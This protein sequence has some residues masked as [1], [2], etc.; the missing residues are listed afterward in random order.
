VYG[1]SS[2]QSSS[3]EQ[4]QNGAVSQV[5][6][7]FNQPDHLLLAQ[8]NRQL[9]GRSHQRQI[10]DVDITAAQS[11]SVEEPQCAHAQRNRAER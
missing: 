9:L 5:Q 11:L 3:I 10:V 2:P 6:S 4:Y 7:P 1:F 8:D